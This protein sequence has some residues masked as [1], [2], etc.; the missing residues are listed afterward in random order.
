MLGQ[1][2]REGKYSQPFPVVLGAQSWDFSKEW[3]CL[4]RSLAGMAECSLQSQAGIRTSC[5]KK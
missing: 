1:E 5:P 4:Q 2:E 3:P